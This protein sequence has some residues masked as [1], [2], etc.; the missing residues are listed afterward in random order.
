MLKYFFP[1]PSLALSLWLYQLTPPSPI[2]I[3][4]TIVSG[5]RAAA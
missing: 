4:E 1:W 5:E 2:K 3:T